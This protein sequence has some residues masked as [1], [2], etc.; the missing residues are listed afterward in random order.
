MGILVTG[1]EGHIRIVTVSPWCDVRY[2]M[3]L[4][5]LVVR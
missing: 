5:G 2:E 4:G 1:G 3:R